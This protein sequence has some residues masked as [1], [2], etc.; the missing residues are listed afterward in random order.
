MKHLQLTARFKI[1]DDKLEEFKNLVEE[2]IS[3]V[4]EKDEETLQYDWYFD[5]EKTEWILIETYP[6]SNA[7]LVHV[8]N[9]GELFSKLLA[10]VPLLELY[11]AP[12]TELMNATNGLNR[13]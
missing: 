2:C 13:K 11:G 3:N 8:G 1:A 4:K 12:S 7:L 5:E 10:F 6:D 9:L